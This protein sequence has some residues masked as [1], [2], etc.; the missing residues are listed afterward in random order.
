MLFIGERFWEIMEKTYELSIKTALV[1]FATR[2]STK[3]FNQ[4]VSPDDLRERNKPNRLFY[5][6]YSSLL[7]LTELILF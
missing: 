5:I 7:I 1:F 3:M 2:R 6:R 4:A